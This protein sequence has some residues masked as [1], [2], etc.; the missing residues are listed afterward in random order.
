MVPIFKAGDSNDPG[1][2]RPISLLPIFSKILEKVIARQLSRFLEENYL[3][4]KTQH[5]FRASLSTENALLTLFNKLYQN[6]DDE[7]ISLITLCDLSK[8]FD[9]VNLEQ[10][11]NKLVKIRI[12]TF[13]F[14]CY[15]QNRTQSVRL[16]R[17]ISDTLHVSYGVPQ[18]SVLG[19]ILFFIFVKDLSRYISDCL[20][21]QY[22][23]DSQFVHT[24]NVNNIQ[25]LFPKGGETLTK[26][27]KYFNANGLMLNTTKTQCMFIGCRGLI[28][29]IP[30]ETCLWVDGTTIVPSDSVSVKNLG[31]YFDT[32]MAFDAHINNLSKKGFSAIIYITRLKDNFDRNAR[33]IVIQS[34]F[35]SMIN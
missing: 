22:A 30:P 31:L 7:S 27:K 33:I 10:L 13:W 29:R 14:N 21:I 32:H 1:N 11:K 35:L 12:D 24:G 18:G 17:T 15:L 25:D 6:I 5:G 34:L 26:I 20:V 23:D 2:Y 8:A 9:S 16:D 3:L 28:S 4:S 19:P